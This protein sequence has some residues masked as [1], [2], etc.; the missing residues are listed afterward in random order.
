MNFDKMVT[1]VIIKV[2]F[3][4]AVIL[5]VIGG[6]FTMV[7]ENVVGGIAMVIFG[8]LVVRVYAELLLVLFQVHSR[9]NDIYELLADRLVSIPVKTSTSVEASN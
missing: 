1:P 8:P 5:C 2:I 9:M 6:L 3:W 7:N 4:I